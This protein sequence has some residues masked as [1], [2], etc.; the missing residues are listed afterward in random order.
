MNGSTHGDTPA[1]LPGAPPASHSVWL[2]SPYHT[3]SHSAWATGLARHSR[4]R[5]SLITQEG[6][7]WKWRMQGGALSLALAATELAAQQGPPDLV[8]ATDMV[9]LPVWLAT[10]RR[11]LPPHTPVLLYMHENQLTYPWR[12]GEKQDLTYALINWLSQVAADRVVFNSQAHLDGWFSALPR[13]LKHFPDYSHLPLVESVRARALV[14]PVGI[15]LPPS[16]PAA[17]GGAPDEPPLIL[18]NQRWEYDKRPDRFFSLLY[19][20][21]KAGADFRL[22]VA[23]ENLRQ[24]PTEFEEARARLG[25]H[26]VH[27]GYVADR[28]AY[29]ALLNQTAL[30]VSTADHEFFGI[31]MLE[32]VAAGAFALLPNRLSYPE[33]APAELH[34]ALL[35]RTQEELFIRARAFLHAPHRVAD[36]R[37]A[38][39]A[40]V[41]TTYGWPAVAA[42]MDELID[43]MARHQMTRHQMTRHGD[44]GGV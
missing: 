23:G 14:L 10:M 22:A 9:N 21:G 30:V 31:S 24:A 20:L 35:Y 6:R 8:I 19:R 32:A 2:L 39:Q 38:F 27:W 37:A 1:H 13:L 41:R 11:V 17:A 42:R 25:A 15:T 16:R 28:D 7:F 26:V 36:E 4:H 3:G 44:G 33:L 40:H 34:D 12:P 29:E 43:Q 5:V 18:W